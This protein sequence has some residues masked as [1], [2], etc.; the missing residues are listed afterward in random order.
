MTET[1]ERP[2]H[3]VPS[4]DGR[5]EKGQRGR[6][7]GE[8]GP[9]RDVVAEVSK[10]VRDLAGTTCE[11]PRDALVAR[12]TAAGAFGLT[13]DG[14][15]GSEVLADSVARVLLLV[16]RLSPSI[17]QVVQ[18]HYSAL[19]ALAR[20]VRLDGTRPR[21]LPSGRYVQLQSEPTGATGSA[22]SSTLRRTPEG[23]RLDG[24]KDY[25]TGIEWAER[26]NVGARF[27]GRKVQIVL[28]RS[29]RGVSVD[30]TWSAF[31]QQDTESHR[32]E[33]KD[34]PVDPG[35]VFVPDGM[36]QSPLTKLAHAA[37]DIG[38]GESAMD[39]FRS[40]LL[41]D[42]RLRNA[43]A[44][45]GAETVLDDPYVR[46]QFG[47]GSVE[48]SVL[49]ARLFELAAIIDGTSSPRTASEGV[50]AA[51][52]VDPDI[53]LEIQ[54]RAFAAYAGETAV[55]LASELFSNAGARAARLDRQLDAYWRDARVHTLL[56]PRDWSLSELGRA[57]LSERI[58][59]DETD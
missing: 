33:L 28:P 53:G 42:G 6:R 7:W 55:K 19:S 37:I 27:E 13:A 35:S 8:D 9:R 57:I 54:I 23:L 30:P 50:P 40:F 34:V 51:R 26:L 2:L 10:V 15:S 48:L 12:L 47:Y 18:T 11:G 45:A 56:N 22:V 58:S 49:R 3:E 38:I 36:P 39:S 5:R 32:V 46:R 21:D 14:G 41:H 59:D 1:E 44:S 16:A 52:A 24:V 20:Y 4:A 25:A 31:G 17:A 29:V 43:A